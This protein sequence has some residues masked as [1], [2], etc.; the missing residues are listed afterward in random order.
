MKI[1]KLGYSRNPWRLIDNNGREVYW[2]RSIKHPDLG[3][4]WV[5][6]P[7]M[8]DTKAECLDRTLELLGLC[9]ARFNA[10]HCA[11]PA[12]GLPRKDERAAIA[13]ANVG[14]E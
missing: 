4:T 5:T 2:Q 1:E 8:G 14:N 13:K 9:F 12:W 7:L 11:N 6:E 10:G 3:Q